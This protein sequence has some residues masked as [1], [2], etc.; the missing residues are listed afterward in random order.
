M[1]KKKLK[2]KIHNLEKDK[3]RFFKEYL[4]E[5]LRSNLLSAVISEQQKE[6]DEL[7]RILVENGIEIKQRK[8]GS[9][10]DIVMPEL[11]RQRQNYNRALHYAQQLRQLPNSK[12]ETAN[13][14][15]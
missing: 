7:K 10:S 8:P 3:I 13:D 5:R 6:L 11:L 1:K 4:V 14:K 12:Q 15:K 2:K 9:I